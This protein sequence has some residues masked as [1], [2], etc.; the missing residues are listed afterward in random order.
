ML[1]HLSAFTVHQYIWFDVY[2]NLYH[3]ICL[4]TFLGLFLLCNPRDMAKSNCYLNITMTS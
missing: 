4:S 2:E 1:T 3:K